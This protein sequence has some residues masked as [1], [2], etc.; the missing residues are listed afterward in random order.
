V[1]YTWQWHVMNCTLYMAMTYV[2][3][4]MT[5]VIAMYNYT[6]HGICHCHVYLYRSCNMSLSCIMY[7]SCNISLSCIMYRSWHVIVMYNV[8]ICT[9]VYSIWLISWWFWFLF[10]RMW[11]NLMIIKTSYNVTNKSYYMSWPVHYT[12]QWHVITCALYMTMTCHELYIIHGNDIC[13][14]LYIIS[15]SFIMYRSWHMS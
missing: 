5:S 9:C 4:F 6:G 7:R 12:W 15:L 2:M 14:D 8:Q 11:N 10:V 1:H 3:K 13:H